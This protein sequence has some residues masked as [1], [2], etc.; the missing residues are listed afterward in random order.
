M[1]AVSVTYLV[2]IDPITNPYVTLLG[3]HAPYD[4]G[5]GDFFWDN[6][7]TLAQDYGTVFISTYSSI[8]S[9]RWR[10]VYS[11]P[12]N[13]RWFGATGDGITDD[14]L[15]IQRAISALDL[16]GTLFFPKGTY[17]ITDMLTI[18][19]ISLVGEDTENTIIYGANYG[20]CLIQPTDS[21]ITNITL[22]GNKGEGFQKVLNEEVAD[23][24]GIAFDFRLANQLLMYVHFLEQYQLMWKYKKM[25]AY[26][27]VGFPLLQL[28]QVQIYIQ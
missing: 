14:T 15:A 22:K 3:Y 5:S 4:G 8:T 24:V 12:L 11:G 18:N 19:G 27:E 16:K 10:R 20:I 26:L 21:Y 25:M 7:S 13:V 17:L 2:G 23:V 1:E 28:V 9:G 6:I